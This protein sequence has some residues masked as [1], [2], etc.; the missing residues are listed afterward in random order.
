MMR[1]HRLVK[2]SRFSTLAANP[3]DYNFQAA[4]SEATRAAIE[5]ELATSAHNYHPI[6][7]VLARG[8]GK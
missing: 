1:A 3:T 8:L 7:V 4:L 2:Q 5:L 6:P